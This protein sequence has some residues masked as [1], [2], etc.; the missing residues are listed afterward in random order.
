MLAQTFSGH[1]PKDK[2][3]PGTITLRNPVVINAMP[4][5]NNI[6]SFLREARVTYSKESG[7]SFWRNPQNGIGAS[8]LRDIIIANNR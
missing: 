6:S 1:I 2:P 3:Y 5:F 7:Q 8:I 4:T